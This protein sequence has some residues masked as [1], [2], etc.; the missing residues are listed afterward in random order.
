MG[1]L[2]LPNGERAI[3]IVCARCGAAE[4]KPKKEIPVK[5]RE[6]R[7]AVNE[8]VPEKLLAFHSAPITVS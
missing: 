4:D 1:D 8:S 7:L 6:V 2:R 3:T 5:Q